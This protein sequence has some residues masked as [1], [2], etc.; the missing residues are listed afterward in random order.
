MRNKKQPSNSLARRAGSLVAL[1]GVVFV[2]LTASAAQA[3]DPSLELKAHGTAVVDGIK[4]PGEW[5]RAGKWISRSPLRVGRPR[6]R[7][8]R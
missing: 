7:S 1:L 6:P 5:D 8:T 4:S 3:H 2:A